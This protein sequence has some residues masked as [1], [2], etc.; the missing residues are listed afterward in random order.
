MKNL[1][2]TK[3]KNCKWF[4][5]PVWYFGQGVCSMTRKWKQEESGE[6]CKSFLK[7]N[8]KEK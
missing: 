6:G 3:C 1:S 2:E 7:M 5:R 4:I 8:D